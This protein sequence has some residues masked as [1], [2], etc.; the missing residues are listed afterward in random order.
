MF[1]PTLHPLTIVYLRLRNG[2]PLLL[3]RWRDCLSI[4]EL[5]QPVYGEVSLRYQRMLNLVVD[6]I[7]SIGEEKEI[8]KVTEWKIK[9]SKRVC[10]F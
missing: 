2:C 3:L 10:T 7:K 1:L 8:E 5:L 6:G 9:V 4:L